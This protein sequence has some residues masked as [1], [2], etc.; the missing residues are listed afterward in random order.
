[1]GHYF[2]QPDKIY[3]IDEIDQHSD[4]EKEGETDAT[5]ISTKNQGKLEMDASDDES[6]EEFEVGMFYPSSNCIV[7]Y[8]CCT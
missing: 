3:E 8:A 1:M 7:S 6:E 5:A 2:V 4:E